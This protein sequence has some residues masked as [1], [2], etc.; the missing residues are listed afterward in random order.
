M[1]DL[2]TYIMNDEKPDEKEMRTNGS[3]LFEEHEYV[4][5]HVVQQ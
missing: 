1:T 5:C 3:H 2:R 4:R